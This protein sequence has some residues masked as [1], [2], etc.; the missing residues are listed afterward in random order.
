MELGISPIVNSGL[1]MQLI[2]GMKMIEVDMNDPDQKMLYDAA[3]KLGGILITIAMAVVYVFSG[4]YGPIAELGVGNAMLIVGQLFIAGIIVLILDELL[5]KYGMGSGISLF[6]STGICQSIIWAA[7]SPRSIDTPN[8]KQYEGAIISLFHLLVTRND[9]IPALK[10]AFYRTHSYNITNLLATVI[11]VATVTYFQGFHVPIAIEYTKNAKQPMQPYPIK[12]FYT[13]NMP[14]ILQSTVTSNM[15]QVSQILYNN[16][17]GV[18]LVRLIGEWSQTGGGRSIPTGGLVYYISP[19]QSFGD[20]IRDPIHV[21]TYIAFMLGSCAYFSSIWVEVS[22]S[23]AKDIAK[24]WE[25][26]GI[27]LRRHR[28]GRRGIEERL[29]PYIRTASTFGGVCVGALTVFADFMGVIGSGTGI[30]LAVSNIFEYVTIYRDERKMIQ[31][32]GS[33]R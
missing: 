8:G 14:I 16:M 7:L 23:T 11:T 2:Q 24:K 15:Y 21:L 3:N 12:L 4:M 30:L 25:K 10:E 6:I 26:D 1:L 27:S 18:F 5:E 28:G 20:I 29:G 17:G 31:R 22:G 33:Y 9:K 32:G 19:I 13:S